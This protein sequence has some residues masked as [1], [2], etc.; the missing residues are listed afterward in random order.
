MR[1]EEDFM[2]RSPV[3]LATLF[4]AGAAFAQPAPKPP[5]GPV[6]A[7]ALAVAVPSP[8]TLWVNRVYQ[9]LLG[10]APDPAGLKTF[11]TELDKGTPRQQVATQVVSS[12]EYRS[13]VVKDLY[14]RSLHRAPDPGARCR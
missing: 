10:R 7:Q 2:K 9:D 1:H 12:A 13:R 14:S 8:N 6:A 11:V 3:A 4:A 5:E